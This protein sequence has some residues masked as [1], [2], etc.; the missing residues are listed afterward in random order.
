MAAVIEPNASAYEEW[1]RQEAQAEAQKQE[2][3]KLESAKREAE[4]KQLIEQITAEVTAK[5]QKQIEVSEKRVMKDTETN[6]CC[7]VLLA[8]IASLILIAVFVG[9]V[10]STNTTN[11]L[12]QVNQVHDRLDKTV[13]FTNTQMLQQFKTLNEQQERLHYGM[14]L[15]FVAAFVAAIMSTIHCLVKSVRLN[16]F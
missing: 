15:S 9:A 14:G 11:V 5:T 2:A 10:V 8:T 13:Q 12:N 16:P 1:K 4:R 3:A 7:F 6:V